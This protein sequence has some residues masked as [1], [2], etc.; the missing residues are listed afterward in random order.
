MTDAGPGDDRILIHHAS[1]LSK[2]IAGTGDDVVIGSN[3]NDIISA[4]PTGASRDTDRV[5]GRG[6]ND[7][8]S[9]FGGVGNRLFG[10]DG[11]DRVLS[12]GTSVSD[13]YGGNG[14]D[15]LFSNGGGSRHSVSERLFG[16]RGN[17]RLWADRPG[18]VGGAFMDPGPG[19]DWIRGTDRADTIVYS[20]GIKKVDARGGDDLLV[21]AGRGGTKV[22]GGSGRDTISYAAHAPPGY[23]RTSGVFVD[24]E[25]GY[26]IGSTRL[27]IEGFENVIGSSFDDEIRG[28]PGVDNEIR[29]SGGN[30]ILEGDRGDRDSAD[31][32]TGQNLCR[33]FLA[34]L[35]CDGNSPGGPDSRGPVIDIDESGVLALLGSNRSESVRI[36]YDGNSGAYLIDSDL[37]PTVAGLCRGPVSPGGPVRCPVDRGSLN[38]LLAYGAGGDDQIELTDSIPAELTTTI[39]GGSGRNLLTGGRSKDYIASDAGTSAGTVIRGRG[40]TDLLYLRDDVSI[41]GEGGPDVIHSVDPCV[42][43]TVSGGAGQDNLVFAAAHGGIRADLGKGYAEWADGGCPEREMKSLHDIE[44]LEGSRFDDVLVLGPLFRTQDGPGGVLGRGGIDVLDS[45]NGVRDTVT[46]GSG[47]RRNEVRADP[48]DRIHWDWGLSGF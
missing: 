48:F 15:F 42:G 19:D 11:S 41:S 33:Y 14:T 23:R 9:D 13:L 31:G 5:F 16:E 27:E 18:G 45:R 34:E 24:L 28:K 21:T 2:V 30:D 39:N 40:N 8:I 46:V 25:A 36:S 44:D 1:N 29:G 12:L 38:G 26:S 20:S 35:N 7:R 4:G 10:Q 32:G 3:G 37:E 47:G 43:G 22:L 6:G 17:D